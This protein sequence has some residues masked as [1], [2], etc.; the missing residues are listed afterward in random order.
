MVKISQQIVLTVGDI[1]REAW[2]QE[3]VQEIS[4]FFPDFPHLLQMLQTTGRGFFMG[5]TFVAMAIYY[6]KQNNLF[7]DMVTV[8][9]EYRNMGIGTAIFKYFE[10]L[11]LREKINRII[12]EYRRDNP[13]LRRFYK[14]LKKQIPNLKCRK[15]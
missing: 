9:A 11:C 13:S 15:I 4:S 12:C 1:P 10:N 14:R 6:K 3:K 7:V 5:N 2:S 8:T